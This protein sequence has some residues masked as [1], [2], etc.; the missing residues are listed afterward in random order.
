MDWR[1]TRTEAR[2]RVL[3]QD[4]DR[5]ERMPLFR[6]RPPLTAEEIEGSMAHASARHA[7]WRNLRTPRPIDEAIAGATRGQIIA[8]CVQYSHADICNGGFHQYFSNHT[9][10]YAS[11]TVE[12]LRTLGDDRRAELMTRAMGRFPRG[13]A[14]KTAARRQ[15]LLDAIDYRSDWQPWIR[16]IEDAYYALDTDDL[17]RRVREYVTS[18]PHEYF[19]DD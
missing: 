14:P 8:Y 2:R 10:D 4:A 16:P 13:V 1:V 11:I 15:R 3:E 12:A 19:L 18:H 17:D 7:F 9:G 6:D 5:R